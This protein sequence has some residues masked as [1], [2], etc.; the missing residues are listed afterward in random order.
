MSQTQPELPIDN[1]DKPSVQQV[2][3]VP[4][5]QNYFKAMIKAQASD[6]HLK[7]GLPPHIRIRSQITATNI[8]PLTSQA[9]EKMAEELL[10]DKQRS[11]FELH[12]NI[13]VA[14]ELENSDRFRVNLFRQR[15]QVAIA[16][17]RVLRDIPGFKQLNLPIRH[18]DDFSIFFFYQIKIL[19]NY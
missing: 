17:R 6:L 13:D 10:S 7:P 4:Q 11:F 15:G 3:S 1:N 5:L 8:S 14:Y 2:N 16:I 18:I 19:L 9:I 12:G